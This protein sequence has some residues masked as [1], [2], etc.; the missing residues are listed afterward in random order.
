MWHSVDSETEAIM[1]DIID[2]AFQD[3]TVIA[4]MHRLTYIARYDKVAVLENGC[5]ARYTTPTAGITG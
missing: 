2:T 5:L 4:V 3:C 1:Q